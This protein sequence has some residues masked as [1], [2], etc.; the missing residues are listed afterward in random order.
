M[1]RA[2]F[3]GAPAMFAHVD[4]TYGGCVAC[5]HGLS[6]DEGGD[7]PL[8]ECPVRILRW[9]LAESRY[10]AHRAAFHAGTGVLPFPW[11]AP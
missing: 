6:G 5:S 9:L 8:E 11:D 10:W 1:T 3:A 7:W 2:S 4:N